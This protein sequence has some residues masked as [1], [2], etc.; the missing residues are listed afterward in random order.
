MSWKVILDAA[1][2]VPMRSKITSICSRGDDGTV[3][4]GRAPTC[5]LQN[6]ILAFGGTSVPCAALLECAQIRSFSIC[7]VNIVALL[8]STVI[9]LVADL[10]QAAVGWAK[11]ERMR[12]RAHRSL[13]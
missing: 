11:A 13:T 3:P 7:T 4:S 5:P 8:P 10:N 1:R 12:R 9:G 2:I 6:R